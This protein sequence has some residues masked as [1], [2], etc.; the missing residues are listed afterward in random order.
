MRNA[1]VPLEM[2]NDI[3]RRYVTLTNFIKNNIPIQLFKAIFKISYWNC[4]HFYSSK[5][6]NVLTSLF[7]NSLTNIRVT[8]KYQEIKLEYQESRHTALDL[9]HH[10]SVKVQTW[11]PPYRSLEAVLVLLQD[12]HVREEHQTFLPYLF[13]KQSENSYAKVGVI[14]PSSSSVLKDCLSISEGEVYHT[15]N[16]LFKNYGKRIKYST[17]KKKK[18]LFLLNIFS[19]INFFFHF[20]IYN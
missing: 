6:N 5:W 8:A 9:L 3:K 12:W 19:S 14:C 17:F 1:I 4:H 7:W 16:L 11:K 10:V 15:H 13:K 18:I 20:L 2:F